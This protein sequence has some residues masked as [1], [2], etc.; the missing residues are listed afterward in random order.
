MNKCNECNKKFNFYNSL[1]LFIDNGCIC[2][3]CG[4]PSTIKWKFQFIG[5]MQYILFFISLIVFE[6]FKEPTLFLVLVIVGFLLFVKLF[7]VSMPLRV[8]R[9][10]D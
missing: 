8:F 9:D 7:P 2:D 1:T 5:I 6:K 3:N 4:T 10:S